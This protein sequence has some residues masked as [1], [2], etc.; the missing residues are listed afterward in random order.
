MSTTWLSIYDVNKG[1]KDSDRYKNT[2]EGPLPKSQG[3]EGKVPSSHLLGKELSQVHPNKWADPS[4][5][6][7]KQKTNKQTDKKQPH[8]RVTPTPKM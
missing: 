6:Q 4:E 1:D 7:N 3:A 5:G 8:W 2:E